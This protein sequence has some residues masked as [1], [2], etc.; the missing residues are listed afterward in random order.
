MRIS[1]FGL[2]LSAS[3]SLIAA[4]SFWDASGPFKYSV[5]DAAGNG[6]G[7]GNGNSGAHGNSG[8]N[9]N[10][11]GNSAGAKSASST[12]GETASALGALNAAHASA[13]AFVLASP[14]SEIGKIKAYY[15]ADQAALQAQ[16]TFNTD[17]ASAGTTL[18]KFT[19]ALTAYTALQADPTNATLQTN[20]NTALTD[21]GLT[22]ATFQTL[23]GE[24]STAQLDA[25]KAQSLLDAASNKGPVSSQ[26]KAAL[27]QLLASKNISP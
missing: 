3:L 25:Q 8:S 15:L 21:A 13:Q 5:A 9:G 27:D 1:K 26:T 23:A 12:K 19:A 4:P 24:Y 7:G 16:A 6:N 2:L 17:L 11:G 20:Y 18:D 10:A 14:K 22:D